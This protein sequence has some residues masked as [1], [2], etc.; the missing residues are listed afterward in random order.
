VIVSWA[1]LHV[2]FAVGFALFVVVVLGGEDGVAVGL[3]FVAEVDGVATG[4]ELGAVLV[5]G[6]PSVA[7]GVEGTD[8]GV[9][10]G[11]SLPPP[12]EEEQAASSTAAA[13]RAATAGRVTCRSADRSNTAGW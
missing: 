12:P 2:P 3:G 8:G 4:V 5:T 6:G 1:A 9:T 10:T 7:D 11:L 13:A